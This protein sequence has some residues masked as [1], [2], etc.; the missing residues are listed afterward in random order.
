MTRADNFEERPTRFP[1]PPAIYLVA[2]AA[3]VVL[4]VLVPL[5]WFVSPFSDLLLACGCLCV[6]AVVGLY[7][8]ALRALHRARTTVSPT[9]RSDHLVTNGAFSLS[10]NPLYLANSMLL[11]GIGFIGG[12]LWF[13]IFA[14]IASFFTQNLA[15]APEERHLFTR[16]GKKYRDYQKKVRRWI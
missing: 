13:F 1:W 14:V 11:V 15:I 5:P 10:R 3:S 16:F 2:I 7:I 8:S 9:R 12:F 6:L 4:T